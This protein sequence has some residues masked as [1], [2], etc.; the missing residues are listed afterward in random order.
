MAHHYLR[1][2]YADIPEVKILLEE[3]EA[4]RTQAE[5]FVRKK[6]CEELAAKFKE[7]S[8]LLEEGHISQVKEDIATW[9]TTRNLRE[10]KLEGLIS[11]FIPSQF[12][13]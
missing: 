13:Y 9:C 5:D 7:W 12:R 6:R 1:R 11:A 2:E 10:R 4:L 3:H 8:T